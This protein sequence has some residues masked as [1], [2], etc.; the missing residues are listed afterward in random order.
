MVVVEKSIQITSELEQ[1]LGKFCI[2]FLARLAL[3][4]DGAESPH[5]FLHEKKT[6]LW[7]L[8]LYV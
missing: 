2:G 4:D 5:Y 3:L 1:C 6:H 7:Y 8:A